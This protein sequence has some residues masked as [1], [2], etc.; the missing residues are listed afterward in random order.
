MGSLPSH[1]QGCKWEV[2]LS[3]CQGP[4]FL[5]APKSSSLICGAQTPRW[6][7]RRWVF[8][9]YHFCPRPFR[10]SR[11]FLSSTHFLN[12]HIS[13]VHFL[14]SRNAI[15]HHLGSSVWFHSLLSFYSCLH[16]FA[17]WLYGESEPLRRSSGMRL[18]F[19]EDLSFFLASSIKF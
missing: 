7:A 5:E 19:S 12:H 1:F 2:C 9:I 17:F 4:F 8:F 16:F 18:L 15:S 6:A 3:A 10:I 11:F 14:P 13:F